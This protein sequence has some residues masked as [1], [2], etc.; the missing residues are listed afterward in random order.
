MATQDLSRKLFELV[1][2]NPAKGKILV[3]LIHRTK[4][5]V[6]PFV[7]QFAG[8]ENFAL[9]WVLSCFTNFSKEQLAPTPHKP[10]L[11]N[12]VTL[13]VYRSSRCTHLNFT[14]VQHPHTPNNYLMFFQ[15]MS[16]D[17]LGVF[18]LMSGKQVKKVRSTITGRFSHHIGSH[19]IWLDDLS[20]TNLE[21]ASLT[22]PYIEV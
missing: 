13:N 1:H 21:G 14:K 8:D 22:L 18:G 7:M 10:T 12:P 11:T 5:E 9:W 6:L 4:G 19:F 3:D 16:P 2:R 17:L 20:P 15:V